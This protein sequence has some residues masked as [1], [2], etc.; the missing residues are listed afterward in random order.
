MKTALVLGCSHAAGS[1]MWQAPGIVQ[2]TDD[3]FFLYGVTRSYPVKIASALGYEIV[4]NRSIPGGSNDAMFRIFESTKPGSYDVVI[5]CWTGINRSEIY[6]NNQWHA[7]APGKD[8]DDQYQ[9]YFQQWI[10]YGI[11]DQAGRLNKIK[12]I[13]ALNALAQQQGVRV[14]NINSFWPVA[15][16][17]SYGHWP[18]DQDFWSW[19]SN[20]QYPHTDLGH[21]FEPAHQAFADYVLKI[22]VDNNDC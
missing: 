7:M 18:V 9:H 3:E 13:V 1:E 14:I 12:N 11:S 5:A 8:V 20:R 2:R 10:T 15:N 4:D 16:F 19:C 21:F 17:S 22:I 6:N